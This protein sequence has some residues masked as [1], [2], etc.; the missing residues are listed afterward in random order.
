MRAEER[1]RAAPEEDERDVD[2]LLS[3]ALAASKARPSVARRLDR[4]AETL[5]LAHEELSE[6]RH[7]L[8]VAGREELHRP[9]FR[10]TRCGDDLED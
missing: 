3:E 4:I 9:A 5:N 8:D 6:L 7:E 10:M 1:T 2:R